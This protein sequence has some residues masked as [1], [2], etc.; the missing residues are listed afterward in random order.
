MVNV[1]ET[2]TTMGKAIGIGQ[3]CESWLQGIPEAPCTPQTPDS[4][5]SYAQARRLS[6]ARQDG[7]NKSPD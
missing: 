2:E 7:W 1:Q 6:Y 5:E 4:L 3:A